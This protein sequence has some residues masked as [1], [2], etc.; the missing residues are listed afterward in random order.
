M[1]DFNVRTCPKKKKE[2]KF[3][4]KNYR[5]NMF[6][7]DK[8]KRNED[9]KE[10]RKNE[11]NNALERLKENDGLKGVD[12]DAVINFIKNNIDS[13][14]DVEVYTDDDDDSKKD[15]FIGDK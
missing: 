5:Q 14:S 7:E 15:S 3:S 11:Y 6:E 13:F 8:Q 1:V 12:A 10:C 2:T 9:M 4:Q